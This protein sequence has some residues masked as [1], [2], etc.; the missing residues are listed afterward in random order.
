MVMFSQKMFKVGVLKCHFLRFPRDIL[1]LGR[2]M[3][4]GD[5]E[6]YIFRF[7]PHYNVSCHLFME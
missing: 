7:S 4:R 3:L 6:E 2:E 5:R 1:K